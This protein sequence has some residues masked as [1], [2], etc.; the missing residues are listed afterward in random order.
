MIMKGDDNPSKEEIYDRQ[1]RLWGSESQ[2]KMAN[3][4]ILY[5]NLGSAAAECLK[6]T[7]LAGIQA[8]LCDGRS[9][10]D[11]VLEMPSS[12]LSPTERS[13][14]DEDR[15]STACEQ[16]SKRRKRM[17]VAKALQPHV[18]ELNPLLE[19]C[20]ISETSS[21]DNEYFGK[22]DIVIASKIGFDEAIRISKATT[23][24]GGKFYLL[25][26]FGF[27]ACAILDLGPEHTFRKE[28][29]KDKLSDE[30]KLDT[31]I[32]LEKIRNKK[33]G[34]TK[35]RWHKKGPPSTYAE[36][37]CILHY[38]SVTNDWPCKDKSVEFVEITKAFLKE[39]GL[40][41][42]YLG[43]D[44]A[45][46]KLATVAMAEIAPVTSIMGGVIGNEVIKA[47]S[48]KG[49]PANNTILLDGYEGSCMNFTV[50][51]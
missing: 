31:Y 6:N 19:E 23:T 15:D 4:K 8:A 22:F 5:V 48:G 24:A 17:T 16:S 40:D 51:E 46:A 9:Y 38:Q 41:D 18:H 36:F 43:D 27:S 50:N 37:K 39:E 2:A 21:Q 29:G 20:E 10:P 26:S 3:A 35:D 11:S 13:S 33:L 12:F 14:G 44:N 47:I 30:C 1:I 7:T 32:S 45:L 34:D 42:N 28:V 49:E 25:H